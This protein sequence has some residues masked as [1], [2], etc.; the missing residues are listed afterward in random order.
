[1]RSA[2][3]FHFKYIS[4]RAQGKSTPQPPTFPQRNPVQ[5]KRRPVCHQ[6][7]DVGRRAP[8]LYLHSELNRAEGASGFP[9]MWCGFRTW[10]C[11]NM[12]VWM[13]IALFLGN[14]REHRGAQSAGSTV[15]FCYADSRDGGGSLQWCTIPFRCALIFIS[16]QICF[17]G[18]A[19]ENIPS[20]PV[21]PTTPQCRRN[22]AQFAIN[23]LM[24]E[25][26]RRFCIC[27]QN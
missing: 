11:E 1:M 24:W 25:R 15:L 8:G 13:K 12:I 17:T 5:N 26:R 7:I 10:F 9:L 18:D 3:L 23:T 19:G 21:L 16:F 22:G 27:I 4:Q 6:C 14:H 2:I 20:R